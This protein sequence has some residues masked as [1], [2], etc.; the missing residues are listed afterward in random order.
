LIIA[1]GSGGGGGGGGNKKSRLPPPAPP[2]AAS[3]YFCKNPIETSSSQYVNCGVYRTRS[4]FA[5]VLSA[6]LLAELGVG[7]W[8]NEEEENA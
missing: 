6:I 4:I 7:Y 1:A 8:K 5:F 3:I 2:T